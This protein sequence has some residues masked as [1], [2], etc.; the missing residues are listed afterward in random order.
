MTNDQMKDIEPLLTEMGERLRKWLKQEF[1]SHTAKEVAR[2]FG[3]SPHTGKKWLQGEL[4]ANKHMFAMV[5]RWGW[6]FVEF[7]Y[8]P[9]FAAYRE[10]RGEFMASIDEMRA[11][12]DNLERLYKER[13]E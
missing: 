1:P 7:V 10:Q 3:A 11:S 9:C 2:E 5:E 13:K 4:P 8:E 6:P 12:L